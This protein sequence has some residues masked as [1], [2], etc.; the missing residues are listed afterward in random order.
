[1]LPRRIGTVAYGE[2]SVYEDKTRGGYVGAINIALEGQPPRRRKVTGAT[3]TE[4]RKK[5]RALAVARDNGTLPVGPSITT[6][7]WLTFWLDDI[8]PGTVTAGTEAM[9]R[10]VVKDWI[11]PHVGGI[12]LDRLTPEHVVAMMRAL[13]RKGLSVTTQKKARTVLRRALTIAERYGRVTRNAA[14]L[15]D[16]PKLPAAKLDDSLTLEEAR[17]VLRAAAGDRLE[18]LAHLV[19]TAGIRQGEALELRWPDVDFDSS[20]ILVRGTKTETSWRKVLLPH[21]TTTLLRE[22][23]ARQIHERLAAR[24]WE[25][26]DLCF[27]TTIGTRIHRRNALRWWHDL[28]ATAGV[29]RR[30]FHATRHTAATLML[31]NGVPLEVVSKT[32]GHAGLAITADIYARVGRQ[33]Q[34][35]AADVMENLLGAGR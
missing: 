27:A 8:L 20:E 3:K 5:L 35:E 17:T 9:Y 30:R 22:H 7:A 4:V 12:R 25:D 21:A 14:G 15:T 16:A 23:R 28:L 33:A 10:Q 29:P 19:L 31:N 6:G 13:E 32:L 34:R 24:T 26:P 11:T 1:M 2:G 18:A